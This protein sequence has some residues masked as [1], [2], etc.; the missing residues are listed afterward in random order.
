[1]L[2]ITALELIN[3]AIENGVLMEQEGMIVVYRDASPTSEEGWYLE[4]KDTLAKELKESK[5]GQEAII[6]A[7]REK[8]IEFKPTDYSWLDSYLEKQKGL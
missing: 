4:D 5:E 1:M 6:S 3:L 7:L 2:Y 8:N